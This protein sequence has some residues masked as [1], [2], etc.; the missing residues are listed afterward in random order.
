MS[1]ENP[2]TIRNPRYRG[3][4]NDEARNYFN[5]YYENILDIDWS[6]KPCH[7]PFDLFIEVPCGICHSCQ[8]KRLNGYRLRLLEEMSQH[9]RN[10]FV[11]LT[12]NDSYLKYLDDE[13]NSNY[14]KP[15]LQWLDNLRKQFG[16]GIRHWFVCEFGSL[17]GRPHYHGILFGIP[18]ELTADAIIST[19]N[20]HRAG[21]RK[22][23]I[24]QWSLDNN[25]R[26]IAYVGN[27]C[28]EQTAHY[29]CKYITK[30]SSPYYKKAVP[31][32]ISSRGL[33]LSYVNKSNIDAHHRRGQLLPYIS[34]PNEYVVPLPRYLSSRIFTKDEFKLMSWQR[35]VNPLLMFNGRKFNTPAELISY[36]SRIFDE[37]LK[38]GLSLDELPYRRYFLRRDDVYRHY[39]DFYNESPH[40]DDFISDLTPF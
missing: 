19:W 33:G 32:I 23:K 2:R 6:L 28:N 35:F 34:T 39:L 38:L 3:M 15:V 12:F 24:D 4:S 31:R 40:Y 11:T 16:K 27:Y 21:S 7:D 26:G 13:C 9:S 29:I 22:T 18:E 14:N 36:R 5:T 1:C 20:C 37:N 8:R 30:D 17:N 25:T 10:A